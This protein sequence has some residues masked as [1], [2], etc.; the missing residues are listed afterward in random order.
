MG[1]RNNHRASFALS[2][3]IRPSHRRLIPGQVNHAPR[4]CIISNI[5]IVRLAFAPIGATSASRYSS[6][7]AGKSADTWTILKNNICPGASAC[8]LSN[9]ALVA[10]SVSIGR[11]IT[12]QS[13]N[14]EGNARRVGAKFSIR[15]GSA[16]FD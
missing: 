11:K 6:R 14:R 13:G 15:A 4:P 2:L 1:K 16:R 7:E 8:S 3:I 10:R 5:L 9:L 12:V